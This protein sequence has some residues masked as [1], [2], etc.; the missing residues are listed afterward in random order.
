MSTVRPLGRRFAG[1]ALA[2][3][4][5]GLAASSP[6]ASAQEPVPAGCTITGTAGNDILTGGK[7][8]ADVICG[9]GGNDTITALGGN[10]TLIGGSGNDQLLG[11]QGNDTLDGGPG[12]DTASYYDSGI[13]GVTVDLRCQASC[14]S[15]GGGGGNDAFATDGGVS[16][17]ENVKGSPGNDVL[18]GDGRTN[19]LSGREGNDRMSAGGGNDTLIGNA[20]ADELYGESGN[21][22]LQPG[23]AL[24]NGQTEYVDGGADGE[25][26]FGDT[27]WYNDSPTGVRVNVGD[28]TGSTRAFDDIEYEYT[29]YIAY[30]VG[31]DS[32]WGSAFSDIISVNT[33][34][35]RPNL[36][37]GY[38]GSDFLE[39]YDDDTLDT[40][41]GGHGVDDCSSSK[42]NSAFGGDP[43]SNCENTNNN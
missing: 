39:V 3:S 5:V 18:T 24:L 27:L 17:V 21:D 2:A 25:S 34:A 19:N 23:P 10:D 8:T 35:L 38:D 31:V 6:A 13:S 29:T 1:I 4:A 20:G 16:S 12:I 30:F 7:R 28:G 33:N 22:A 42:H 43:F 9:L 32:V 41:D 26:G 14:G 15:S 37:N 11:G 36:L 40:L